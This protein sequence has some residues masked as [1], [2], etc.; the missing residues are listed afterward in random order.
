MK[1]L[2]ALWI[3]LVLLPAGVCAQT[4]IYGKSTGVYTDT[5]CNQAKYFKIGT[6][7]Q[8]TDDGKLYK[9]TGAAVEEVAS[10]ASVDAASLHLD[11]LLTAV[12]IASEA[13][14]M[15]TF[16]GSTIPD[17]QTAKAA[18]QALETAVEGKMAG[19]GS[20]STDGAPMCFNGTGGKTPKECTSLNVSEVVLPDG[21]GAAPT[22]DGSLKYDRTLHVLQTGNGSSNEEY[23]P[24]GSSRD[25]KITGTIAG[26]IG[27]NSDADGMAAAD[28]T[29][30]GVYGTL[31]IATGAGTWIL[32]TAV[33]GMNLCLMDSGTAHD[34]IL[35]VTGTDTITLK[36][37]EGTAGNGITNASGSTTGDFVC[38]VAIAAGKWS[39]MGMS[40]TWAAQ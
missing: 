34:L 40:G 30:A 16:T 32:P 33:A 12:G 10:G 25:F 13:T 20:A 26:K 18:I 38:V 4:T 15:G 39:T 36:G 5:N 23:V 1:K 3:V 24:T 22:T 27:I 35:D 7:C 31:F 8:D 17:N 28:M 9:G 6:L 2:F 11:D 21:N 19:L 14:H 29:A 37:T